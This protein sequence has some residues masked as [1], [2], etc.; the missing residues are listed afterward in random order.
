MHVYDIISPNSSWNEKYFKHCRLESKTHFTYCIFSPENHA[1]CELMWK[2][3]VERR[4]YRCQYR[5][6]YGQC[7]LHAG[8]RHTL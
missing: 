3:V 6:K 8:C 7:A 5:P 4:G 1:D 2:N